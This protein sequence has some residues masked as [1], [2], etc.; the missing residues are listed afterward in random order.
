MEANQPI[1][2]TETPP[3]VTPE[4]NPIQMV[5]I[6][7][8]SSKNKSVVLILVLLIL[9]L[10]ALLVYLFYQNK[11]LRQQVELIELENPVTV[12]CEYNGKTYKLGEGFTAT[13]GCNSCSCG[14]NGAVACTEMACVDNS[15][16]IGSSETDSWNTYVNSEYTFK[17]PNSWNTL[18][19]GEDNETLMIAPQKS[20][21]EVRDIQGGFGG[22]PFLIMTVNYTDKTEPR[23]PFSD[24]FQIVTAQEY[25]LGNKIANKYEIQV[26]KNSPLGEVGSKLVTI[27]SEGN[28]GNLV[29]NLHDQA[30]RNYFD[31]ILSTFQFTE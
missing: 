20:I 24:E 7:S 30:Y 18:K 23:A 16:Q 21:D 10:L 3:P 5:D 27:I 26:I 14:E 11:Q 1:Q 9:G 28:E 22:G 6:G 15:E 13:D 17:Y 4:A 8:S 25:N 31:Q 19:I 29:V 2:T 12:T